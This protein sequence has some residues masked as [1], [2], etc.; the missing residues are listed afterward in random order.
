MELVIF[1]E[2]LI[3]LFLSLSITYNQRYQQVFIKDS[4]LIPKLYK[5]LW[6]LNL[7]KF[8]MESVKIYLKK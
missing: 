1:I 6:C 2:K 3:N 8:I 5:I 4:L 7:T